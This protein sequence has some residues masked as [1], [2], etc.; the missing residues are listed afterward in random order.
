MKA[1][2]ILACFA[3][4]LSGAGSLLGQTKGG[5][6]FDYTPGLVSS[7]GI[8]THGSSFGSSAI[9]R[10]FAGYGFPASH[11]YS[12]SP[13]V[14]SFQLAT[15]A[16]SGASFQGY[17]HHL[18]VL[19]LSGYPY[20]FPLSDYA[21]D[22]DSIE[23]GAFLVTQPLHHN[24][25]IQQAAGNYQSGHDWGQD[26][27]LGITAWQDFVSYVKTKVLLQPDGVREEFRLGFVNGYGMHGDAAFNRVMEMARI[28]T[29]YV[30]K[31]PSANK[32]QQGKVPASGTPVPQIE[33]K[34]Q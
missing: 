10:N 7:R 20:Y 5:Y 31:E 34:S 29:A 19:L 28:E 30:P 13:P 14:R 11:V 24:E 8:S 26:L 16:R 23:E 21:A 1:R 27:R 15:A 9:T 2:S 32:P 6:A 22:F 18:P 25:V 17:L 3:L 4:S 12:I 33:L